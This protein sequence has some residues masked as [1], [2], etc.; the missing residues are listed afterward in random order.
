[1]NFNLSEMGLMSVDAY[2]LKKDIR[3]DVYS[4]EHYY[5]LC[6]YKRILATLIGD[7]KINL[8][9]VIAERCINED[10]MLRLKHIDNSTQLSSIIKHYM[11]LSMILA[12]EIF[13]A[14]NFT[15][16]NEKQIDREGYEHENL[17]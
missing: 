8:R 10:V 1:M 12:H 9:V 13:D 6:L 15:I 2:I 17:S 3:F 7:Q 11:K 5:F 14:D 16:L 4:Q